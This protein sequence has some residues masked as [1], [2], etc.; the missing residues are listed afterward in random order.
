MTATIR[1]EME[2]AAFE[3]PAS[4]LARI[5]RTLAIHV[6]QGIM[7]AKAVQLRDVNGNK[8]GEFKVE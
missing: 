7:P 4:E 2:N 3:D 8:V 5:L 6:E 1:I